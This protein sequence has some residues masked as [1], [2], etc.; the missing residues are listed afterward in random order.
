MFHLNAEISSV[1]L[2]DDYL[3]S[4]SVLFPQKAVSDCQT[5][6]MVRELA[7]TELSASV[8]ICPPVTSAP[9]I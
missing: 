9:L 7:Y 3:V 6:L 5:N 2:T 4:V 8:Y 1:L